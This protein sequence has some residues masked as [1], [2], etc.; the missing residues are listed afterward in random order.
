[1]TDAEVVT[2]IV[3]PHVRVTGRLAGDRPVAAGTKARLEAELERVRRVV[4]S[5]GYRRG[6]PAA[7]KEADRRRIAMLEARI[8]ADNS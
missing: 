1:D 6:A 8:G 2:A 5:D 3:T 4:G 7:V